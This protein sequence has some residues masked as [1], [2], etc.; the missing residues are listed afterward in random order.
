MHVISHGDYAKGPIYAR[1]VV[2][3]RAT[4]GLLHGNSLIKKDI[5]SGYIIG[6][7]IA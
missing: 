1:F 2:M 6:M 7:L 3:A 5:A 4:N